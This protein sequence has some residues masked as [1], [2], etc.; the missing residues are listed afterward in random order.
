MNDLVVAIDGP[1][2]S[3]KSTTGRALAKRLGLKTL[4][5]GASYRAITAAV[6]NAGIDPYDQEA[7]A[8]LAAAASLDLD[9]GAV[10]NNI[11]VTEQ[12]RSEEVNQS[13]SA[14]AANAAVREILV[15]WQREWVKK[16]G[17]GIVEGRDIGTVVFPEASLK[18]YLTADLEERGARRPEEGAQSVE[19]RDLLDSNRHVSPLRKADDALTIDTTSRS[20]EDIVTQALATLEARGVIGSV[21]PPRRG[22]AFE[23]DLH[24]SVFYRF[25]RSLIYSFLWLLFRP[26]LSGPGEVPLEGAVVIAPVHRSAVDFGFSIFLTKRKIFFMAKDQIWKHRALGKLLIILGAFP[27]HRESADRSALEHAEA[28]LRAGGVLVMFPEGT[29]QSGNRVMEIM[30]GATFL[31]ARTGATV[32]PMGIA[33]SEAAWPRGQKLPRP[34]RV[35][36]YASE[37]ITPPTRT[38]KGR[39]SRSALRVMT[40]Q[41]RGALEQSLK[42]A[43]SIARATK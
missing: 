20:V 16:H 40:E 15:R 41:L 42:D 9:S 22:S 27:V 37:A 31:A 5:T 43:A 13:V 28:V 19:R 39:V 3:G 21:A 38:A 14:I 36:L 29:R 26:S 34:H 30:E 2:G 12:L 17:G 18:L 10:V 1:A 35:F 8:A 4:D 11:D 24:K 32:I 33:G 7:V 6:L 23:P 25:C